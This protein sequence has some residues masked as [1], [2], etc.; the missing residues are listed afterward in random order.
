MV[1]LVRSGEDKGGA[2]L[3]WQGTETQGVK[4]RHREGTLRDLKDSWMPI[5]LLDSSFV[6]Q[7][8]RTHCSTQ[9]K[10]NRYEISARDASRPCP[11]PGGTNTLQTLC[12]PSPTCI[13]LLNKT[14]ATT[15]YT[16]DRL[17]GR[18]WGAVTCLSFIICLNRSD[19][20]KLLAW[21]NLLVR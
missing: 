17:R 21:V 1:L 5:S 6:V 18:Y 19:M 13:K 8:S 2:C 9:K 10:G 20:R 3:P 12:K 4:L 7:S 15:G 16:K 14:L 11:D